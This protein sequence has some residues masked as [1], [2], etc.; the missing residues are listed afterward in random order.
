MRVIA[1]QARG[2]RLATIKG[3]ETRPTADRVKEA[4]FNVLGWRVTGA[5][6]LDLFAG[7]GALGIEALS[8]GAVSVHLV[9]KNRG[10]SRIIS[11][12]LSATGLTGGVVWQRDVF[13]ACRQLLAA[14]QS[15]D[16]IF[17][18]PP[19]GRGLLP[20]VVESVAAGLLTAS[21]TLVL[22]SGR[23]DMV[24]LLVGKMVKR[25]SDRYGDTV[26]HY[27]QGEDS[28]NRTPG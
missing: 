14:G 3:W 7:S 25:R 13:F 28:T 10:A 8:R 24:P 26:I 11:K 9:E 12:N 21:G 1:G 17:A 23:D 16:L 19:Y 27:Y 5:R 15:F 2:R 4:I 6:C 20:S 18:D 22:E